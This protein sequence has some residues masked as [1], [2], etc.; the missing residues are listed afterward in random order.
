MIYSRYGAAVTIT[1]AE[2]RTIYSERLPGENRIHEDG[3]P[4]KPKG[5]VVELPGCWYVKAILA[6]HYR[7]GSGKI[8]EPLRDGEW[9]PAHNLVAD[10]GISEIFAACEAVAGSKAA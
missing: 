5:K 8:G 7:D 4:K 6:G 9:F 1:A 10:D 3:P 2:Q